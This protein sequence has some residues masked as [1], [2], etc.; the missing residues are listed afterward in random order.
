MTF[1]FYDVSLTNLSLLNKNVTYFFPKCTKCEETSWL[2]KILM[3]TCADNYYHCN[4]NCIL[5]FIVTE[6]LVDWKVMK[7]LKSGTKFFP[8]NIIR[9]MSSLIYS[10]IL[11]SH[12]YTNRTN[13]CFSKRISKLFL[14]YQVNLTWPVKKSKAKNVEFEK[15]KLNVQIQIFRPNLSRGSEMIIF[16]LL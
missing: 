10:R 11:F 13:F 5:I 8:Q 1:R 9:R 15:S 12:S 7:T 2:T 3:N 14:L 4:F 16:V 6:D